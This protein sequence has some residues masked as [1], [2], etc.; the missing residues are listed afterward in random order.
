M[1]V[2]SIKCPYCPRK[3]HSDRGLSSHINSSKACAA[4]QFSFRNSEDVGYRTA[5]Q[6]LNVTRIGSTKRRK[7]CNTNQD[8]AK[9]SRYNDISGPNPTASDDGYDNNSTH[10][11]VTGEEDE[12]SVEQYD[13]NCG[14][15]KILNNYKNYAKL[16]LDRYYT[17][18]DTEQTAIELLHTLRQTKASLGTY[19]AIMKWHLRT[20]RRKKIKGNFSNK[21]I[22]S[23]HKLYMSLYERYNMFADTVN[24]I[25]EITLPYS[26]ARAKIV[27]NSAEWCLQSLLTDPR[28]LDEDYLFHNDNPLSKQ[29]GAPPSRKTQFCFITTIE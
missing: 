28:I 16:A 18:T 15:R 3:F 12:V 27:T 13:D 25:H 26:R 14:T 22:L 9:R 24:V 21:T 19:E 1:P 17:F 8:N 23:R 2:R 6:Y 11:D 5:D 20:I 29:I 4:K 7:Y 10:F